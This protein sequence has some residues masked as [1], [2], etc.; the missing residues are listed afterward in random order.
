M[1]DR[2]S[3]RPFWRL[4]S[5]RQDIVINAPVLAGDKSAGG[6]FIRIW[7]VPLTVLNAAQQLLERPHAAA[8][9][10][11][12]GRLRARTAAEQSGSSRNVDGRSRAAN[13]R[14]LAGNR[15]HP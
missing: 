5:G 13:A 2:L 4:Q 15:P 11:P 12:Q 1:V 14:Q 6:H 3:E 9:S 8:L 7:G 10:D